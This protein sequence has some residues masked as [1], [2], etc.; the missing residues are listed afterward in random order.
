MRFDLQSVFHSTVKLYQ[1]I[2]SHTPRLTISTQVI[3][4]GLTKKQP[5]GACELQGLVPATTLY[6]RVQTA[7][8][9]GTY[10]DVQIKRPWQE[11]SRKEKL[12]SMVID[13]TGESS[14]TTNISPLMMSTM[15]SP[16]T[17]T[18]IMSASQ[19]KR[20]RRSSKQAS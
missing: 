10:S 3:V 9:R 16:S 13:V 8:K 2:F 4:N 18:S 19:S 20:T 5:I 7:Q 17:S 6:S 15:L 12:A 14:S 11:E 1:L